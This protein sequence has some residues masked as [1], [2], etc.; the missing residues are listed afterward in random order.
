MIDVDTL[1]KVIHNRPAIDP[2]ARA[3]AFETT[4][5]PHLD[6]LLR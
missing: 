6:D 1:K 5:L 3:R 2:E 4:A